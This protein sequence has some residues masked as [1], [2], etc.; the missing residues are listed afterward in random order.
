MTFLRKCSGSF[1]ITL[2]HEVLKVP[3]SNHPEFG[4]K[5]LQETSGFTGFS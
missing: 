3:G 2:K 4:R 1:V 5:S